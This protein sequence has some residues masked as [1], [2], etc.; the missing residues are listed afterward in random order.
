MDTW[1]GTVNYIPHL[2]VQNPKSVS[3]PVRI[4]FDA[5]WSQGGGPSL[6]AILA[7]GPNQFLN[8][9]ASVI[10]WFRVGRVAAHGDVG[11]MFNTVKEDVTSKLSDIHMSKRFM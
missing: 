5:S 9:L 1:K 10:I 11:K 4:V 3:T 8:N 6:N 2:A 7:K